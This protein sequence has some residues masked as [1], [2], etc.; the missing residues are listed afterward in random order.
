MREVDRLAV[1][2]VPSLA[3]HVRNG[4]YR[5]VPT[6]CWTPMLYWNSREAGI[7]NR[8]ASLPT[9]RTGKAA[10]VMKLPLRSWPGIR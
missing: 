9:A 4:Q 7:G 5:L 10:A 3:A 6:A 8:D 1:V 2:F